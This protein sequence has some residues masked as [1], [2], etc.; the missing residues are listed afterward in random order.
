MNV[1]ACSI[2]LNPL[3]KAPNINKDCSHDEQ[4]YHN[5]EQYIEG[6]SAFMVNCYSVIGVIS[7]HLVTFGT[8]DI[9]EGRQG[10]LRLNMGLQSED[11]IRPKLL[12]FSIRISF[13]FTKGP[14]NERDLKSLPVPGRQG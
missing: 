4:N 7:N 12:T 5:H 9:P 3:R 13:R 14:C 6:R 1:T 2:P 10:E 11:S 8:A